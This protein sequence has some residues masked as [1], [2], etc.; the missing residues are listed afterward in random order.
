MGGMGRRGRGKRWCEGAVA[1]VG[2]GAEVEAEAEAGAVGR[3][4]VGRWAVGWVMGFE[5]ELGFEFGCEGGG[6]GVK[7]GDTCCP[8]SG[9]IK[10][11]CGAVVMDVLW[12]CSSSPM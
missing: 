7:G 10:S 12:G 6:G 11:R 5:F 3:W 4:T 9:V 2:P 1:G 8:A